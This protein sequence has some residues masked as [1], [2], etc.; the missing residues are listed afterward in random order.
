MIVEKSVTCVNC[1]N[2]KPLFEWAERCR[3][4]EETA[5]AS[6]EFI[7]AA[8]GLMRCSGIQRDF[9]EHGLETGICRAT[10]ERPRINY[11]QPIISTD[12]QEKI[13]QIVMIV[14][15]PPVIYRQ[16]T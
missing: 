9:R 14:P 4:R 12:S 13:A 16:I 5:T 10:V 11:V 15:S 1:P 8:E 2:S 3:L 6:D 7:V